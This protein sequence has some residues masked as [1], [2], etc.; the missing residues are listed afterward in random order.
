MILPGVVKIAVLRA[1]GLGDWMFALPALDALRAAY[2]NA[3]IALLGRPWHAQ[4]LEGRPSP[5]DRVI[6][7][8]PSKGV[9]EEEGSGEL[10]PQ[11]QNRAE[12]DRFFNA[13]RDERFDLAIQL[14]G[15]GHYSNP[16]LLQLGAR[17]TAGLRT[18]D[19]ALLDHWVPY[20]YFQSETLRC[21]EVVS[22]VGAHLQGLEPK[23]KVTSRDLAESRQVSPESD[24]PLVAI[25]PGASDPRRRWPPTS[26][27]VVGDALAAAGARVVLTGTA[28][29]RPLVDAV[30]RSMSSP[31]QDLCDRL[32]TNGLAGLL[33][34]CR[35]VVANDSGPLHLAQA[36]GAATV[37]IYW[38]G[39][40]INA[41][42]I[43]RTRHR[44]ILSWRLECPVCGRNTIYDNCQHRISFVADVPIDQVVDV[45]LDLLYPPPGPQQ[46]L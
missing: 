4:F 16:F 8:P 28:P 27:A 30:L 42:P 26:F 14:H 25:H 5:I 3:D 18:A 46:A 40:L 33:S 24:K 45:A 36:V 29:E 34:R 15:G 35:V 10:H 19:A 6:V 2:P 44:P 20:I 7:V 41:D 31:A 12:L 13:M 22:L 43:T 37:G 38:C 11:E 32:T 39:N 1:N 23:V 9:R 17:R 21:L